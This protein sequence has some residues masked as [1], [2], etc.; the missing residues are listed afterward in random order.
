MKM[1]MIVKC[2]YCIDNTCDSCFVKV[3]S[4]IQFLVNS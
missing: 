4:I 1:K 3:E 2:V